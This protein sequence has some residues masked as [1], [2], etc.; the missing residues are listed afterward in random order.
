M[1]TKPCKVQSVRPTPVLFDRN[2]HAVT[3]TTAHMCLL[4]ASLD[5]IIRACCK[6]DHHDRSLLKL[7][8]RNPQD[9][10]IQLERIR[11]RHL[12]DW[13]SREYRLVLTTRELELLK[14]I[15]HDREILLAGEPGCL[16]RTSFISD[17]LLAIRQRLYTTRR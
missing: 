10:R 16:A 2:D 15:V 12:Q 17:L 11:M 5:E 3:I 1:L 8:D 7:F 9:V 4:Q 6:A 14:S 13:D